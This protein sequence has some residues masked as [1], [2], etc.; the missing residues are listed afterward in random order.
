MSLTRRTVEENSPPVEGKIKSCLRAGMRGRWSGGN[1]RDV[2]GRR[3]G[4]IADSWCSRNVDVGRTG[5]AWGVTDAGVCVDVLRRR[6][7]TWGNEWHGLGMLCGVADGV[8]DFVLGQNDGL[9]QDHAGGRARVEVEI[10]AAEQKGERTYAAG[11]KTH[12]AADGGAFQ[13]IHGTRQA[14]GKA[15]GWW[16]GTAGRIRAR[17]CLRLRTEG[18]ANQGTD[19]G[20]GRRQSESADKAPLAGIFDGIAFISLQCD[21][22]CDW[23]NIAIWK[24]DRHRLQTQFSTA[25]LPFELVEF[26]LNECARWNHDLVA[27]SDGRRGLSE[28]IIT[29]PH[30]AGLDRLGEDKGQPG[31]RGN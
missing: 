26:S 5:R 29:T 16:S 23:G 6:L 18:V 22:A 3:A 25:V 10:A 7:R 2:N 21:G 20:T 11:C 9:M 27:R 4:R 14:G 31:P 24:G 17:D 15:A 1:A 12:Y 8:G 13:S 30:D 19:A 28:D